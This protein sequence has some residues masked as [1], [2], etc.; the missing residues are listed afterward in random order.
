MN[1]NELEALAHDLS[2]P[3]NFVKDDEVK[4]MLSLIE[5]DFVL[6]MGR[7]LTFG[8]KKYAPDNWKL[9]NDISRYKDALLRHTYAYM[10]GEILDSDSGLPHTAHI[11]VNSM[12][13]QWFEDSKCTLQQRL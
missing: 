5:P 2:V 6:M 8:A 13:L 9:C 7:V 1:K 10:S 12:F 11:A 4:P 3:E